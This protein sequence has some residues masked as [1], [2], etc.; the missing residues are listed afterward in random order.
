MRPALAFFAFLIFT[1]TISY[2][3]TTLEWHEAVVVLNDSE[4]LVGEVVIEPSLDMVLFRSGE[5]RT[6]YPAAQIKFINIHDEGVKFPRKFISLP[7]EERGRFASKLYE[8][9]LQGELS[10][11]R[12]PRG[13][14]LPDMDDVL[15]YDYFVKQDDSITKLSD[16]RKKIYPVIQQYYAEK[17]L[18]FSLDDEQLNPNSSSDAIKLIQMYNARLLF[19]VTNASARR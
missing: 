4:V 1:G 8:V 2:A 3:K 6:F 9:V 12:K 11:I 14:S 7:S 13:G 19:D 15:S 10:V 5:I 16:F 17:R 18:L